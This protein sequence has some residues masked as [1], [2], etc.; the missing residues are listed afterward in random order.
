MDNKNPI[1][2][3]KIKLISMQKLDFSTK[4]GDKIQGLKIFYLT[5]PDEDLKVNYIGGVVQNSFI[6][7]SDI[8]KVFDSNKNIILPKNAT[9]ILELYST[10]KPPRAIDVKID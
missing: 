6:P 5:E 2:N 9:L 8:F 4:D 10:S 3:K 1:I 7:G